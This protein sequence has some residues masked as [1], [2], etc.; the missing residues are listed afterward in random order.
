MSARKCI[1]RQSGKKK[2]DRILATVTAISDDLSF[3]YDKQQDK[4][5]FHNAKV[6]SIQHEIFYDRIS[7]KDKIVSQMPCEEEKAYLN[8]FDNLKSNFDYLF[9]VDTNTFNKN[10]KRTSFSVSCFFPKPLSMYKNIF[11]PLPFIGFMITEVKP[12][13]NPERIGWYLLMGCIVNNRAYDLRRR[14]GVIVDSELDSLKRINNREEPYYLN[15]YLPQ[16]IK[17][18]YASDKGKDYLMN[19]MLSSCHKAANQII[20]FYRRNEVNWY[21]RE[22]GDCNFK[23]YRRI[24]LKVR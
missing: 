3:S 9:A 4:L 19:T 13:V 12:K 10:G 22:N 18:L 6:E 1:R 14:I 24:K 11:H 21:C 20:Q 2:K 16:N 15:Y 5:I 17:L 7:G 23:G 8:Q